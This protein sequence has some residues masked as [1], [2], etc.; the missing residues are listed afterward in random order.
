MLFVYVLVEQGF[1]S[2]ETLG[3]T[4]GV[5]VAVNFLPP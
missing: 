3:Y 2:K 4:G 1:Y 5:I